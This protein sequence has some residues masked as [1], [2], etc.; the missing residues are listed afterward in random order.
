MPNPY[1]GSA[2]YQDN[3]IDQ[4]L[5]FGRTTAADDLTSLILSSALVNLFSQSGLGKTSLICAAV[6]PR[7]RERECFPVVVRLTWTP[8]QGTLEPVGPAELLST[9]IADN[10]IEQVRA[11]CAE[12]GFGTADDADV[13]ELW[14]FFAKLKCKRND[15]YLRPV[16]VID[17]FEELFTRFTPSA[18]ERFIVQFADFVANRVPDA[19]RQEAEKELSDTKPRTKQE[20]DKL[21][22]LAYSNTVHDTKVL[23][24]VREDYFPQLEELKEKLPTIFRT[25]YRLLP[26]TAEQARAAITQPASRIAQFGGEA[27]TFQE[28]AIDEILKFLKVRIVGGTAVLG[29]T[30]EPLQL[31]ILC[32]DI[33]EHRGS[34]TLITMRDLGGEKGMRRVIKKYYHRV[35]SKLSPVRVG[36]NGRRFAPLRGN[37]L[38]VNF[39]RR[40]ASHLCEMELITPQGQRN[41]LAGE[42]ISSRFGV[43]RRD[44]QTMVDH[45]LLRADPRLSTLFYELSHDSL[46]GALLKMRKTRQVKRVGAFVVLA[47]VLAVA[48]WQTFVADY[49]ARFLLQNYVALAGSDHILARMGTPIVRFVIPTSLPDIDLSNDRVVRN[50]NLDNL[51]FESLKMD[52]AKIDNSTFAGSMFLGDGLSLAKS[53]VQSVDFSKSRAL[54][55][56]FKEASINDNEGTAET[57]FVEAFMRAAE[58]DQAKIHA[59][60]F[61]KAMLNQASFKGAV[62]N[63]PIRGT[64]RFTKSTLRETRFDQAT[65]SSV[66]FSDSDLQGAVFNDA[67]LNN[68]DFSGANLYG[69]SFVQA[70]FGT[71]PDGTEDLTRFKGSSWWLAKGWTPA[72]F[73]K[74]MAKFP[75]E[76]FIKSEQFGR[77]K[78]SRLDSI[79]LAKDDRTEANYKNTLAW[80]LAICGEDL[81]TAEKYAQSAVKI[82]KSHLDEPIGSNGNKK[83]RAVDIRLYVAYLDTLAYILLQQHSIA[84]AESNLREAVDRGEEIGVDPETYYKYWVVL[85]TQGKDEAARQMEARF[86]GYKPGHEQLLLRSFPH[87]K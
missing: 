63:D 5:F 53:K 82:S 38:F 7:L 34:K 20:E 60:D 36:W 72:Q 66:D 51:F 25:T 81:E 35:L 47:C 54:G 19:T 71:L 86:S 1:R 21:A 68:V 24:A 13:S 84:E 42:F 64:V 22:R 79:G 3:P 65:L 85:S 70:T 69:T 74:L 11:A 9:N 4:A 18:R 26:L 31:Q 46:V 57:K 28:D 32:Q 16:L 12:A 55:A 50:V 49:S 39:P 10:L 58:F 61:T 77:Q 8:P 27:F 6:L 83:S 23:I 67:K 80:F 41:S 15:R 56:S 73:E 29:D 45:Y 14:R 17:Q 37:Y 62:I 44:L 78:K 2:P 52:N 30:I 76:E 43:V 48:S 40:A 59:A 87:P 75:R 33:D